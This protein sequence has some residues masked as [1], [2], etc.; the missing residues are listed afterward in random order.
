AD[1]SCRPAILL[2]ST[3]I[4]ST[5]SQRCRRRYYQNSEVGTSYCLLRGWCD[6]AAW[7]VRC[8]YLANIL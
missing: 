6:V 2:L 8:C 1:N 4:L 5:K 3:G 7:L